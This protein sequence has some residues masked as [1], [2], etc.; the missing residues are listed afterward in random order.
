MAYK[1]ELTRSA[2]G[3]LRAI[4]AFDRRRITDAMEAQL[5]HQPTVETRNRK[6][7]VG[8]VP[9]FEHIPPVWELRV[10][11]YRVFYDVDAD[12]NTVFVRAVRRK[13]P[14]QTTEDVIR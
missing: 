10:Q 11:D 13:P 5:P 12:A 9:T 7:L 14:D 2:A 1:I 3:E 4:R 6:C 8:A